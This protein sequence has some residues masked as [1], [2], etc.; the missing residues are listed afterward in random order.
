MDIFWWIIGTSVGFILWFTLIHFLPWPQT[1]VTPDTLGLL[2]W[3]RNWFLP[4]PHEQWLYHL[5]LLIIPPTAILIWWWKRRRHQRPASLHLHPSPPW[6]LMEIV[7][8]L[9][10]LLIIFWNPNF[11]S[12]FGSLADYGRI[13]QFFHYNTFVGA[14]SEVIYGKIPLVNT[15]DRYG[16]LIIFLPAMIFRLLPFSY[17]NF[18]LYLVVIHLIYYFLLYLLLRK[19]TRSRLLSWLGLVFIARLVFLRPWASHDPLSLPSTTSLRFVADLPLF[20]TLFWYQLKRSRLSWFILLLINFL[21]PLYNPEIG[22]SLFIATIIFLTLLTYQFRQPLIQLI[23]R[24]SLLVT[25]FL[26]APAAYSLLIWVTSHQLPQ[27]DKFVLH[28]RILLLGFATLPLPKLGV[29]WLILAI[30]QFAILVTAKH[31]L[32]RSK[33]LLAPLIGTLAIYGLTIFHYYLGFSETEHL[34][35]VSIPALILLTLWVNH[36][37][38][39][40]PLVTIPITLTFLWLLFHSWPRTA[41]LLRSRYLPLTRGFYWSYPGTGFIL[42]DV[43]QDEFVQ[44]AQAI[45]ATVPPGQPVTII[46]RYDTLL[47]VMSHRASLTSYYFYDVQLLSST[48]I[49]EVVDQIM[50]AQPEFI[51]ADPENQQSEVSQLVFQKLKNRLQWEKKAG[52]LDIY[53]W[54]KS[55]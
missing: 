50:L 8:V 9:L 22:F 45:A 16:V 49:E 30:Y 36:L 43:A 20:L 3:A 53:R 46:S 2:P 14:V 34:L 35:A 24:I 19:L 21:A 5:G 6:S 52:I 25:I 33:H 23:S 1:T 41:Q 37:I 39:K 32:T 51:F 7:I 47:L 26:S 13:H 15:F 10:T 55:T 42:S 31:L 38:R 18:Y 40:Y 48:M 11:R 12:T 44:T 4:E 27:W 17:V 29:Y 54:V 28:G